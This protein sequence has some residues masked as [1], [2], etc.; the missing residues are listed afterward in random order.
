M[1]RSI[2]FDLFGEKQ[3]LSFTITGIVELE[4]ALGKSIQQIVRSGNA[5]FEFCLVALP[6]CLKR[7]NPHL[8]VEKI[9]KYLDVEDNSIDDIATLIIH[10]IAASGALGKTIASNALRIYYP[11]LYPEP[12]EAEESE[13]KNA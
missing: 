7:I 6:I 12:V 10:A 1:K 5:G 4:K 3:S 11:E 8:Y 2:P 13:E 9:E